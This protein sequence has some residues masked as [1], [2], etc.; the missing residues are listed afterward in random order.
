MYLSIYPTGDTTAE[1]TAVG[2]LGRSS[3]SFDSVEQR[4][5]P[6]SRTLEVRPV[7]I[8]KNL[9]LHYDYDVKGMMLNY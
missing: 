3:S 1:K 6:H 7:R 4:L 9:E 8:N 2:R 5:I